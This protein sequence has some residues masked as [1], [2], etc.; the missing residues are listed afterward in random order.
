MR[1][2]LNA[3]TYPLESFNPGMDPNLRAYFEKVTTGLL[4]GEA[5]K[6]ARE[7][8]KINDDNISEIDVM[9]TK[10]SLEHM[11]VAQPKGAARRCPAYKI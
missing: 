7:V 3:Y 11:A 6:P 4:E 8:A 10:V 9:T 2:H 1:D 5:G